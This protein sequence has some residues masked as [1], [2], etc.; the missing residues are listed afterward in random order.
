MTNTLSKM[1]TISKRLSRPYLFL[2]LIAFLFL[3]G[4]TS[5]LFDLE[6]DG[7]IAISYE[8]RSSGCNN[9]SYGP[10][11]QHCYSSDNWRSDITLEDIEDNYSGSDIN[12]ELNCCV[13]FEY[14]NAE[15]FYG[16]CADRGL[17]ETD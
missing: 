3:Y 12:C 5:C 1:K 15:A 6:D 9:Y 7:T 2:S 10:W 8:V 4:Q 13:S 11:E 14:R 17:A 16:T